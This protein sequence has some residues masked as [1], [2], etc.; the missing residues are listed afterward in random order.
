MDID[1]VHYFEDW[2]KLKIP[3][4]IKQPFKGREE[5]TKFKIDFY[6]YIKITEAYNSYNELELIAEFGRYVRLWAFQCLIST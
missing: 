2:T 6:Q 4:E 5:K 3:S 1:F